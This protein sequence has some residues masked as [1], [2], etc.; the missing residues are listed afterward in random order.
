M[1]LQL[2]VVFPVSRYCLISAA[3][4][5]KSESSPSLPITRSDLTASAATTGF[6]EAASCASSSFVAPNANAVNDKTSAA[7]G[8][9]YLIFIA[10]LQKNLSWEENDTHWRICTSFTLSNVCRKLHT[11]QATQ[12]VF[13]P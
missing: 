2:S 1:R 6:S 11:K 3:Y 12:N 10:Y 4:F 9:K 5:T 13:A 8:I 7:D